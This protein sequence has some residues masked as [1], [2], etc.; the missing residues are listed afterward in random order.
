M[1]LSVYMTAFNEQHMLPFAIKH[2]RDRFPAC[3]IFVYN[4]DSTDDTVLI[5]RLSHCVVEPY[6]TANEVNDYLLTAHK[7][8][9]WKSSHTDW[10]CV[11]D[12]DELIDIDAAQLETESAN[13]ATFINTCGYDMVSLVDGSDLSSVKRGVR[14]PLYDKVVMFNK[15]ATSEINYT[16]GAHCC[17]P[18]GRLQASKAR[19]PLYHYKYL[20]EERAVQLQRT[21]AKRLS[22]YNK[23]MGMGKQYLDPEQRVRDTFASVRQSAFEVRK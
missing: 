5:A 14:A 2:Y 15:E 1:R 17:Y 19:Y 13:G 23:A 8:N 18:V 9:C 4:N 7:S 21:T 10:V 12:P 16:P 22:A 3:D 20:D 11:C 6:H